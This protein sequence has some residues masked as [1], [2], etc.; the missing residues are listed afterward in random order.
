MKN[1]H[2][3]IFYRVVLPVLAAGCL[4]ACEPQFNL[5]SS[6]T[7]PKSMSSIS[8]RSRWKITSS[9][10]QFRNLATAIDSDRRTYAVTR[11]PYRNA[12]I[13]I[14]LGRPCYFNTV[15]LLHG[16]KPFGFARQVSLSTSIDG[17]KYTLQQ[18]VPGTRKY[19]YVC[20]FT[21]MKARYIRL[22]ALTPGREPWTIEEVY[23]Q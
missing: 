4:C 18:T 7:F 9:G 12:S 14:D 19:T 22:T 3:G 6:Q 2:Y 15:V 21:P 20:V 13:T 8:S 17:K 23:L 5:S 1:G 11:G 10:A 16:N